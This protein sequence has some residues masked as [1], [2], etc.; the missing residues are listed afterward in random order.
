MTCHLNST[1]YDRVV[2]GKEAS[3]PNMSHNP[4]LPYL[5]LLLLPLQSI[6]TPFSTNLATW[7]VLQQHRYVTCYFLPCRGKQSDADHIRWSSRS[8]RSRIRQCTSRL[9]SSLSFRPKVRAHLTLGS[10]KQ[11]HTSTRPPLR[12]GPCITCS[13]IVKEADIRYLVGTE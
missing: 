13:Y 8:T 4:T 3:Q 6:Y 5:H 7:V 2:S 9:S 10:R 12:R 1:G 11:S